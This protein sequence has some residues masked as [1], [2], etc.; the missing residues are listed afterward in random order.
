MSL[1]VPHSVLPA[2]WKAIHFSAGRD[3]GTRMAYVV[4]GGDEYLCLWRGAVQRFAEFG[5]KKKGDLVAIR[6]GAGRL[7]SMSCIIF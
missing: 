3:V 6:N 4:I 1:V 2:R 5:R 7:F